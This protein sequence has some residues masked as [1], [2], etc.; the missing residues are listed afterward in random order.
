[1]VETG[2]SECAEKFATPSRGVRKAPLRVD[3]YWLCDEC[4]TGWT[5]MQDRSGGIALA[6]LPREPMGSTLAVQGYRRDL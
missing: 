4:A 3:R 1:M 6:P 5:L 2:A